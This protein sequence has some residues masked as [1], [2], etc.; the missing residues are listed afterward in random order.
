[1][2]TLQASKG[3]QTK[4]ATI[5]N[6]AKAIDH[7]DF[8]FTDAELEAADY[9]VITAFAA[10]VVVTTDATT[11]TATL[12]TFIGV[13]DPVTVSGNQNINN[14]QFIRAGSTDATVSIS[15]Y[16]YS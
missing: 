13:E 9:A 12:G 14:L 11:P 16:K 10:S 3:Y 5:T 2:G 6:A 1:M 15:L 7:A 8:G 4:A